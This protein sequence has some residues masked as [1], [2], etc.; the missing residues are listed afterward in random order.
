MV[1]NYYE[2][3]CGYV[4]AIRK[5]TD[6]KPDIAVV[7]GSGLGGFVDSVDIKAVVC[8]SDLDGFPQCSAAGHEGEFVF[9]V[10][11]GKKVVVMQGR[12][13]YYEGLPMSE[14]VL[15]LR[16]MRLLG[17][18]T[19]VLTNAVGSLNKN[20]RPGSFITYSDHISSL[21]PS[22]MIGANIDE[23]GTRFP[24]M[25]EVYSKKLR[26]IVHNA[27][28]EL[29]ITVHEGVYIQ[30]PG[31]QYETPAEVRL[32]RLWGADAVGMST[33]CEATAARHMGM[34]VCGIGCI[35][36]MGCGME[37]AELTHN[38]VLKTSGDSSENFKRLLQ[39][40]IADME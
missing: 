25:S 12:I 20:Y 36:N 40:I 26:G 31:S 15:P 22:P 8:Y 10:I 4:E 5:K 13:H 7:L 9:G 30:T 3:L 17:A 11:G 16:V 37:S 21:V 29:G 32:Y 14:V 38:E 19:V 33:A 28:A 18:E 35:T 34:N 2:R 24:D 1:D 27:A 23:L 6:F 39:K